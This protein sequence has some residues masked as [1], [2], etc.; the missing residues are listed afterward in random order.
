MLCRLGLNPWIQTILLSQSPQVLMVE[1]EMTFLVL[2]V[3]L[4]V[5]TI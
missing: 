5:G 3:K 2:E 1:R 4:E